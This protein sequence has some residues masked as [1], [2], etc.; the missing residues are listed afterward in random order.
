MLPCEV[1]CSFFSEF[2]YLVTDKFELGIKTLQRLRCHWPYCAP[3]MLLGDS[4]SITQSIFT[5]QAVIPK[6]IHN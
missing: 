3:N 1:I 4:L 2:I 5:L 6:Q